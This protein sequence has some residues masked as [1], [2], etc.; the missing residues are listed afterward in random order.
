MGESAAERARGENKALADQALAGVADLSPRIEEAV[1]LADRTR[2]SADADA[3]AD[4][5]GNEL[6]KQRQ[7]L[8]VKLDRSWAHRC[9]PDPAKTAAA[10]I[11]LSGQPAI[12]RRSC[13]SHASPGP[14][15]QFG[16]E[17]TAAQVQRAQARKQLSVAEQLRLSVQQD[18]PA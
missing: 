15:A 2:G 8:S 13:R 11:R 16:E 1:V 17:Q 12:R 3:A 10:A 6:H 14:I 7:L 18:P 4:R 9:R 5:T